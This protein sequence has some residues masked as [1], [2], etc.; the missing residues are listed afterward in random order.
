MNGEQVPF[1]VALRRAVVARGLTLERL[2]ERLTAAG[3]PVSV[4]TLSNWQRGQTL[5]ATPASHRAVAQLEHILGL[6]TGTLTGALLAYGAGRRLPTRTGLTQSAALRLRSGFGLADPGLVTVRFDD[7][8]RVT[9][10]RI[11]VDHRRTMRAERSGVDRFVAMIAPDEGLDPKIEIGP[12]GRLGEIRRD[13]KAGLVAAEI[14]FD[15]PL[16]RGEFYPL[17][18]RTSGPLTGPDGYHGAWLKPGLSYYNLTVHLDPRLGLTQVYR[19][20][21]TDPKA[22]H[23]RMA[24]LRLI[25][26]AIAHL[27][28]PEPPAGFHGIRWEL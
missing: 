9:P 23:K 10:G 11:E 4:S 24:D 7:E 21:R 19:V 27:W 16:A 13:E 25:N 15:E 2:A 28:L 18:Y 12:A 1:D 20:W 6:S 5:P 14:L 17:S 3:T 26:G 22:P 8:V